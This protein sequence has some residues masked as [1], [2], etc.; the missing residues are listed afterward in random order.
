[1]GEMIG[2]LE[3]RFCGVFSA[4]YGESELGGAC[5][6]RRDGS[7]VA[8]TGGIGVYRELTMAGWGSFKPRS[9]NPDLG[10]P[11]VFGEFAS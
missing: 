11:I 3:E 10:H 5:G 8:F 1:M 2:K 4:V 6:G 7:A 9:E